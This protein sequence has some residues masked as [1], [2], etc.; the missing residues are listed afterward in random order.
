MKGTFHM[1]R[2]SL[3]LV[4]GWV[5][6]TAGLGFAQSSGTK[7]TAGSTIGRYQLFQGTYSSY[8]LKRQQTS[9]HAGI[10]LL[11]TLTGK[12]K[13]YLNK[14]DAEGNYV[15]TWVNTETEKN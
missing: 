8:D 15:E 5:T 12:V 10:F 11:D 6:L 2:L 1:K 9:T 7:E 3:L 14:I 4:I 13:R